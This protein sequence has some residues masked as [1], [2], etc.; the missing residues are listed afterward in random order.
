M[1]AEQAVAVVPMPASLF[2]AQIELLIQRG[3]RQSELPAGAR[4]AVP[5]APLR[6][7]ITENMGIKIKRKKN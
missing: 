1:R 5:C 4:A 7:A 3:V 2:C 6:R